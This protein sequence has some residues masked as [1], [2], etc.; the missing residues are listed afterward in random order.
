MVNQ[1]FSP[2][3]EQIEYAEGLVEAFDS[4]QKS[5]KV[6]SNW[7]DVE[8]DAYLK[9]NISCQ[10]ILTKNKKRENFIF[11]NYFLSLGFYCLDESL[12]YTCYSVSIKLILG[13][14]IGRFL[15][16]NS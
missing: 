13:Y 9:N 10:K 15:V 1:A 5:G 14:N 7:Q 11:I 3:K 16:H 8:I 2:T 4:H 6:C 12:F